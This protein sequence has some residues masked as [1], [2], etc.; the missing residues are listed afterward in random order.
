MPYKPAMCI[1]NICWLPKQRS[2]LGRAA[3]RG[4]GEDMQSTFTLAGRFIFR[5]TGFQARRTMPVICFNG[6]GTLLYMKIDS[7]NFFYFGNH[8]FNGEAKL[9]EKIAKWCAG[10]KG[11]HADVATIQTGVA[12]PAEG[13]ACFNR[14]AGSD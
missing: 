2:C 12:F 5:T 11:C 7:D 9:D 8:V 13:A 10:T 4:F 3:T 14:N 6:L 1:Y